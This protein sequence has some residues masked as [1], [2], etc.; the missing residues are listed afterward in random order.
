[1]PDPDPDPD[2][3]LLIGFY[4]LLFFRSHSPLEL[5]DMIDCPLCC[6]SLR[7]VLRVRK[8]S[9]FRANGD[10]GQFRAFSYFAP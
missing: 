1:M 6:G 7:A 4:L 10:R 5:I 3:D 8:G 9:L 2:L